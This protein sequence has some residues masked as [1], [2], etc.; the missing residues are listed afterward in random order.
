ML[1]HRIM[2]VQALKK[3]LS[4]FHLAK[5]WSDVSLKIEEILALQIICALNL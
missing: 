3:D 2:V 4:M 1:D 5:L